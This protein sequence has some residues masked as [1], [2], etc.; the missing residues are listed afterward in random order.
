MPVDGNITKVACRYGAEKILR[1]LSKN[2]HNFQNKDYQY[3]FG[4]GS[5]GFFNFIKKFSKPKLTVYS[6]EICWKRITKNTLSQLQGYCKDEVGRD[7]I[8][9]YGDIDVI[10]DR[11]LIKIP[12]EED[13]QKLVVLG[14]FDV[15]DYL[16]VEVRGIG[17]DFKMFNFNALTNRKK[18]RTLEEFKKRGIR[19]RNME[20]SIAA[21]LA[22]G[23]NSQ[24]FENVLKN[25]Y[26]YTTNWP[27]HTIFKS[28]FLWNSRA[29]DNDEVEVDLHGVLLFVFELGFRPEK[30][31]YKYIITINTYVT[32][33]LL[34]F[35]LF[36]KYSTPFD[37]NT[38]KECLC[39][40]TNSY[41][42]I[43]IAK[44]LIKKGCPC[45]LEILVEYLGPEITMKL[46]PEKKKEILR[47]KNSLSIDR[48]Q[49]LL[50]LD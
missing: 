29:Y 6:K 25:I 43:K 38:L 30:S 23:Y 37:N 9:E 17:F 13:I 18:K 8:L 35:S 36:Y 12:E 24:N 16:K 26:K 4:G 50:V 39:R 45:T 34:T 5:I 28:I 44:W 14:R 40:I 1:F 41:N 31:F 42:R 19:I 32:E 7:I 20:S 3:G 2:G 10:M 47:I 21:N 49:L 33:I 46:Y 27:H 48:K 22:M 15:L 11:Q